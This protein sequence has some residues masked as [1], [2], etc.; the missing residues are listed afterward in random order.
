MIARKFLVNTSI[1]AALAVGSFYATV[2]FR[3]RIG[4]VHAQSTLPAMLVNYVS[5]Y[6]S[7]EGPLRSFVAVR[8]NGDSVGGQFLPRPDGKEYLIR[9]VALRSE[10][11]WVSI[12]S[13]TK[14]THTTAMAANQSVNHDDPS[15]SCTTPVIGRTTFTR[16]IV[17][18][19]VILSQPVVHLRWQ[20]KG[21]VMDSW[22]A[23]Q[24]GCFV[25]K[26][27]LTRDGAWVLNKEAV[28]I[29]ASEPDPGLFMVPADYTE[30]P[31]SAADAVFAAK[32]LNGDSPECVRQTQA[33]RDANYSK[34]LAFR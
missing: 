33:R 13:D 32:F 14:V 20:I 9:S 30:M 7:G 29:T 15:T 5:H 23:P 27:V 28:N 3:T 16:T 26:T 17:G 34:G 22:E 31:P 11:K 12:L 18:S 8:S 21:D 4:I 2:F 6:P 24:L 1:C 25:L 19:D 10:R